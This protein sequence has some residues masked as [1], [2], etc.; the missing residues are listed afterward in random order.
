MALELILA[1][2]KNMRPKLDSNISYATLRM[3]LGLETL[4]DP[5]QGR[6]LLDEEDWHRLN[7]PSKR[8]YGTKSVPERNEL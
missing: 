8:S 7:Q 3:L 1:W 2:L 6:H 4:T 5:Y